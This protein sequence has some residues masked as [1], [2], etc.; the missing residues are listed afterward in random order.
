MCSVKKTLIIL[1]TVT[2]FGE[3]SHSSINKIH[4]SRIVS[5]IEVNLLYK[6]WIRYRGLRPCIRSAMLWS[7]LAMKATAETF[8]CIH[9]SCYSNSSPWLVDEQPTSGSPRVY[10]VRAMRL[11]WSIM[12]NY[13]LLL[14]YLILGLS[15]STALLQHLLPPAHYLVTKPYARVLRKTSVALSPLVF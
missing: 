3:R 8:L 6:Y 14:D 10:M 4:Y 15:T 12:L 9:Q 13:Q 1:R 11:S 7:W 2:S 5:S